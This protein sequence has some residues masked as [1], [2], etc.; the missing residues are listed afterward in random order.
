MI[1]SVYETI[2]WSGVHNRVILFTKTNNY[3]T[4]GGLGSGHEDMAVMLKL[5]CG[6][7]GHVFSSFIVFL[8]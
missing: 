6:V 8:G 7:D 3:G 1:F 5:G 4:Y 2:F